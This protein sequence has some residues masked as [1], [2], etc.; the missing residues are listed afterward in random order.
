MRGP[1]PKTCEACGHA[2]SCGGDGCWCGQI[3]MTEEQ[4]DWIA[5][6]FHDCLCPDC[7][8]KV[9]EGDVSLVRKRASQSGN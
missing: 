2:F 9:S 4:M 3:G 8:R 5:G 1:V 7:L 6:R